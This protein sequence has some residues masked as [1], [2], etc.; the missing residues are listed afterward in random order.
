MEIKTTFRYHFLPM[1]LVNSKNVVTW[2][3]ADEVYVVT[4]LR[5]GVLAKP[6]GKT[7]LQIHILFDLT[8]SILVIYLKGMLAK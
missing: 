8:I 5:K 1:R 2:S 7:K 6:F 4:T 3:V